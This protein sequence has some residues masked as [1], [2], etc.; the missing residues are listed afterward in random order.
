M[1]S[2]LACVFYTLGL[3]SLLSLSAAYLLNWYL[4]SHQ[5]RLTITHVLSH[6]LVLYVLYILNTCSQKISLAASHL[7]ISLS[8]QLTSQAELFAVCIIRQT[9][10]IRHQP[11]RY[12]IACSLLTEDIEIIDDLFISRCLHW[13]PV[14]NT[15]HWELIWGVDTYSWR[16]HLAGIPALQYS[17]LL[18][19]A[20]HMSTVLIWW[21]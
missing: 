20:L 15:A 18:I 11:S 2:T 3:W 7:F 14:I 9:A 6:Q 13:S 5:L 16:D 4:G 10:L 17:S 12:F 21:I 19:Y 8:H 1:L